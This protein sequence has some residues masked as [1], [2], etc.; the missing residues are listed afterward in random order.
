VNDGS[1]RRRTPE[2]IGELLYVGRTL[3]GASEII[4]L[5]EHRWRN[6][7]LKFSTRRLPRDGRT[8]CACAVS[9]SVTP[10]RHR[11]CP[12]VEVMLFGRASA[13]LDQHE[14]DESASH[15]NT[16]RCAIQGCRETIDRQSL[17][18]PVGNIG[19]RHRCTRGADR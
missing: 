3:I 12:A 18:S 15:I 8:S 6:W 19:E 17:M 14:V 4:S 1:R 7:V 16:R 13:V 9:W 2:Q 5:T 10:R 11:E